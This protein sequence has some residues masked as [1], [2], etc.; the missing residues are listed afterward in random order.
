MGLEAISAVSDARPL[1]AG[2]NGRGRG[3][4]GSIGVVHRFAVGSRGL[5]T[6]CPQS[7]ARGQSGATAR[8]PG[9][10]RVTWPPNPVSTSRPPT[11]SAAVTTSEWA[12]RQATVPSGSMANVSISA[13]TMTWASRGDPSSAMIGVAERCSQR[14]VAGRRLEAVGVE[15]VG[16]DEQAG[17]VPVERPRLV[18]D[19]RREPGGPGAARTLEPQLGP[20]QRRPGRRRPCEP[21]VDQVAAGLGQGE[22]RRARAAAAPPPARPQAARIDDRG[23]ARLGGHADRRRASGAGARRRCGRSP[24]P[25]RPRRRLGSTGGAPRRSGRRSRWTGSAACRAGPGRR[26]SAGRPPPRRPGSARGPDP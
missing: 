8:W 18:V 16:D 10:A 2:T 17:R 7:G 9:R 4:T 26:S 25:A 3:R 19:E 21:E 12:T 1:R 13:W 5:S 23:V 20:A 22:D 24:V 14:G 6:V 11:S 15:P